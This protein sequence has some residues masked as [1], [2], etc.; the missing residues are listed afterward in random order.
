MW[1]HSKGNQEVLLFRDTNGVSGWAIIRFWQHST[2]N[3]TRREG[4]LNGACR[5]CLKTTFH[6]KSHPGWAFSRAGDSV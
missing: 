1:S 6:P 5:A 2:A 4:V 3:H